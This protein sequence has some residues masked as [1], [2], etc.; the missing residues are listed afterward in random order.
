MI[1]AL[2]GVYSFTIVKIEG[3]YPFGRDSHCNLV[4]NIEVFYTRLYDDECGAV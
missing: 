3:E 2:V 4:T 1:S